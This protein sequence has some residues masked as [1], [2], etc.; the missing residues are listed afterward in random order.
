[1]GSRLGV[2]IKDHIG[3]DI[4]YDH[5]GAQTIGLDIA[6]DGVTATLERVRQMEPMGSSPYLWQEA[7]W[8]EGSLLID[9]T[10]QRVVWAEESDAIYLPRLINAAIEVTWPGWS[11]IW[12]SEGTRGVLALCGVNPA[13]IFTHT[14]FHTIGLDCI[15]RMTPWGEFPEG[16][17]I[18]IRLEDGGLA[19]WEGDCAVDDIA[20]LGPA[21]THHLATEVL[22]RLRIGEPVQRDKEPTGWEIPDTGIH[23][24]FRS[25]SLR[26]WSLCDTDLGLEAFAGQW[27]DWSV[28]PL[29][30]WYEWQECIIGRP[31]RTW[32]H[33]LRAF[34]RHVEEAY[35]EGRRA[36]PMLSLM[37]RMVEHGE[38]VVPT[39]VAMITVPARRQGTAQ[40]LDRLLSRLEIT[41]PLPPA[42]YVNRNGV[43]R[44]PL[45]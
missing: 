45:P 37:S 17:L 10:T 30:D 26:W 38:R 12:S 27:P 34:R 11:A 4:R 13:T 6:L 35:R 28:E 21:N 43:V 1:M 23:V 39:P 24:D 32:H 3:W 7:S 36:N 33:E 8:M 42:R 22:R 9:L 16:H 25:S 15:E 2:V 31:I 44:Q 14:D 20:S 18:S 40:D 5:W 29:G 19:V 41:G